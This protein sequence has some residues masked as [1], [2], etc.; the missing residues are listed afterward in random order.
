M[1]ASSVYGSPYGCASIADVESLSSAFASDFGSS[2][3]FI[4]SIRPRQMF[5]VFFLYQYLLKEILF[6]KKKKLSFANLIT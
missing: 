3:W 2:R 5:P 4:L 1:F 6:I